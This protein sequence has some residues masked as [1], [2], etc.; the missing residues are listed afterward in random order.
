MNAVIKIKKDVLDTIVYHA[1]LNNTLEC[2]GYL[3]GYSKKTVDGIE[4][5]V[6][7]VYAEKILGQHNSFNFD[8]NYER[9]AIYYLNENWWGLNKKI[10]LIGNY[11][12]HGK[13][14]ALFSKEDRKAQEMWMNNRIA[15]LYSPKYNEIIGD[16]IR[17]DGSVLQARVTSYDDYKYPLSC[18]IKDCLPISYPDQELVY[19]D[20][21]RPKTLKYKPKRR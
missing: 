9:R 21:D 19:E 20:G 11:H 8:P 17:K 13:Y 2:G 14:K 3:Y 16:I 7:D 6:V 15:L 1:N 4:I 5:I 12:S 18:S 10:A